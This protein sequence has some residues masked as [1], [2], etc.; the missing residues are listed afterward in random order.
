MNFSGP[1]TFA[2]T[3]LSAVTL[4]L[5][6][7][8]V[9]MPIESV[10]EQVNL[11]PY[12]L[13]DYMSPLNSQVIEFDPDQDPSI[14][15]NTGPIGDP[16]PNDRIY[17]RWFLD[18]RPATSN[19]PIEFSEANGATPE[20]LVDGIFK[21]L[22]PCAAGTSQLLSDDPVHRVE[23]VVADRN[24]VTSEP[25][26]PRPRQTLPEDAEYFSIV[27]FIRFDRTRCQ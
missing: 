2:F 3:L 5:S 27:W 11:P 18:Y 1:R 21:E 16:N 6:G 26:D 24:F 22:R 15:L 20:Q 10:G 8:I 4:C 23:V 25:D 17:W 19:F 14:L 9:P 13:A 7:C 12:Y